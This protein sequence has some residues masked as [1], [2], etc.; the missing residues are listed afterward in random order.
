MRPESA[1]R[2]LDA[3]HR[4]DVRT[5]AK[6]ELSAGGQVSL[7]VTRACGQRRSRR[8][9]GPGPGRLSHP[10]TPRAAP[11]ERLAYG[12]CPTWVSWV[13]SPLQSLVPKK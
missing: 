12:L 1:G 5:G 11:A 4:L 6:L 8:G 9:A 2:A 3:S 7:G 13:S 10:D